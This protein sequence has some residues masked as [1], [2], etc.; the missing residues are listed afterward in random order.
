MKS[1]NECRSTD[2]ILEMMLYCRLVKDLLE[3]KE[4]HDNILNNIE[5]LKKEVKGLNGKRISMGEGLD[6]IEGIEVENKNLEKK[7]EPN[8]KIEEKAALTAKESDKCDTNVIWSARVNFVMFN[9]GKIKNVF[10]CD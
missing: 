6:M 3:G 1:T 7:N 2:I 8:S 10:D 4:K 9:I 5:Q